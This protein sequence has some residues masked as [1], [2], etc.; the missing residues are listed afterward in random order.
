MSLHTLKDLLV[1]QLQ[2][3]HATEKHCVEILPRLAKAAISPRL[4][5][6]LYA[7]SDESREHIKRIN[8]VLRSL[9]DAPRDPAEGE[10]NEVRGVHKDLIRIIETTDSDPFV[11]D[12]ALLAATQHLEHV[13]IAGYGCA[14]TWAQVLGYDEAAIQLQ[15]TLSEER[16]ADAD[17]SRIAETLNRKAISVIAAF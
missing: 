10:C 8:D 13:E 7:H 9:G 11:R 4:A 16:K 3:L 1:D 2:M 14:R 12:A 17:L 15:K 5:S 6:M